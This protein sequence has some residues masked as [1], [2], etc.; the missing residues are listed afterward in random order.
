[1]SLRAPISGLAVILGLSGCAIPE[2]VPDTC[3]EVTIIKGLERAELKLERDGVSSDLDMRLGPIEGACLIEG[4]DVFLDY[5]F[6]I[7]VENNTPFNVNDL[8]VDYFIAV[9]R[10]REIV[11]KSLFTSPTMD[12]AAST[13]EVIK[14]Q[15]EQQIQ[16]AD[17]SAP[18]SYRIMIGFDLPPEIGLRQRDVFQ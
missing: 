2:I 6:D 1:M 17:D 8:S 15:F 11:D 10:N 4:D 14:E 13:V 18:G 16:L 5:R 7:I 3:P 12:V 9:T